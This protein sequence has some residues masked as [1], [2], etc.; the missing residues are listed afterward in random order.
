MLEGGCTDHGQ[1]FANEDGV[2]RA[3]P[4]K[5][6]KKG[7]ATVGAQEASGEA[8]NVS[9]HVSVLTGGARLAE[10]F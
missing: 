5:G 9:V 6:R 7:Q 10:L 1:V 8:E 2:G 3:A 4:R